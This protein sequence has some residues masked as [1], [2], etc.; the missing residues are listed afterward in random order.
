MKFWN[1]KKLFDSQKGSVL[2][3]FVIALPLIILLLYGLAQTNLKIVDNA[4]EQVA[5]Y[6]LE[7]EAHDVLTRITQDLRAASSVER[8]S[9][10]NHN[11]IDIDTLTIKYHAI[12]N[13]YHNH[14]DAV[15]V[16]DI[17][18]T[19]VYVVSNSYTLNAKRRDDGKNF[20]PIT[21]GNSFGDTVIRKLKYTKLD[22]RV[23][24]IT[25]E[26]LSVKTNRR[27]KVSTAVFMPAC[28]KMTGF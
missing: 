3:E 21:G 17:I 27:I 6:I 23:I 5:D 22:E 12:T 2:I 13:N 7:V 18:D 8:Q 11:G 26:M 20:N 1:L 4:K 10:F 24:H 14:S 15:K 28:E 9:R 25:L 19:R 16:I